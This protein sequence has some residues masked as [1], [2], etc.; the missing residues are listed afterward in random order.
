M[1]KNIIIVA[2]E[3]DLN[4]LNRLIQ[5]LINADCVPIIVDNSEKTK[6]TKDLLSTNC[7]IISMESNAGIAKAQNV[8]I[9]VALQ[10]NADIIGFFDQDSEPDESLITELINNLINLGNVVIAPV[11]IDKENGK[12]YPSL[13]IKKSGLSK[14]VYALNSDIPVAV[15]YVI[16]SG[17]FT[18]RYVINEVGLF[19]EDFFIDFV[20]IEWC[21]RCRKKGI[22]IFV[23]P[24]AI[25]CH[26]IGNETKKILGITVTVH[27][28]YRTYYK[29]RN[30]FLLRKKKL[31][32]LFVLRQIIPAIIHNFLLTFDKEKGKEYRKFY[33]AGIKDGLRGKNGKYEPIKKV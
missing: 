23:I 18:T 8:G 4:K 33:Y 10:N 26:K 1:L 28:P 20:D 13:V 17:T 25:L 15:D 3:P 31:N 16:S 32:K 29:V 9:N 12:E 27:S 11:A 24:N 30:S 6:L 21:L 5:V 22:N 14:E 2:Y 7:Q 19:D